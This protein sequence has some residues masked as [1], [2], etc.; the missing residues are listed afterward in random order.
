[1]T[2]FMGFYVTTLS[3]SLTISRRLMNNEFG[4]NWKEAFVAKSKDY[5]KQGENLLRIT[6]VRTENLPNISRITCTHT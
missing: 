5:E 6:Y 1:M 3:E 4:M 2:Y